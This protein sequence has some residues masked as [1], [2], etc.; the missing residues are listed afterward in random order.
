[1]DFLPQS[2]GVRTLITTAGYS[3]V[4]VVASPELGSS[5]ERERFGGAL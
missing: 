1:M 5:E 2:P 4:W 3:E